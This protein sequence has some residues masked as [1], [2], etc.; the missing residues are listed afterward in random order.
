MSLIPDLSFLHT[1]GY[2]LL[3]YPSTF[4]MTSRPAHWELIVR[5]R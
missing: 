1:L 4:S 2:T 5:S 3:I